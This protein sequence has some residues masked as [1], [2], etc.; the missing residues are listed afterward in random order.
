MCNGG[1]RVNIVT[2]TKHC[3]IHNVIPSLNSKAVNDI[4]MISRNV[5]APVLVLCLKRI[6][7]VVRTL[8]HQNTSKSNME[9]NTNTAYAME[10]RLSMI[11]ND[12]GNSSSHKTR[13]DC[14]DT[15]ERKRVLPK[16]QRPLTR[17]LPIFSPDLD[18]RQ[19][20]ESA[21]HQ[22]ALCPHVL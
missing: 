20:I 7:T 12:G 1:D 14:S 5:I 3:I 10:K 13:K 9:L 4:M 22:I 18:L 15:S 8:S 16:H 19:H 21:G 2:V 6:Q 17:Y 11:S